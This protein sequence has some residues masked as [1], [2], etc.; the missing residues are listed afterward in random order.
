[1][2]GNLFLRTDQQNIQGMFFRGRKTGTGEKSQYH[3]GSQL[4]DILVCRLNRH[5]NNIC[6]DCGFHRNQNSW[7]WSFKFV[8]SY[9]FY[10][11]FYKLIHVAVESRSYDDVLFYRKHMIR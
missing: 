2:N 10:M 4:N 1:M 5:Q 11:V 7:L 8:C 9:M 6:G 3:P